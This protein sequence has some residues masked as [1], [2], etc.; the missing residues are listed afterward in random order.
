M[1]IHGTPDIAG[2]W[3]RDPRCN[4]GGEYSLDHQVVMH[5]SKNNEKRWKK[6]TIK[7]HAWRGLSNI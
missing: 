1:L 4:T 6:T 2:D 5:G 3:L 7:W